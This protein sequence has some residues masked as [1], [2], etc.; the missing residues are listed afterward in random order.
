MEA[1]RNNKAE[2]TRRP[3][4]LHHPHPPKAPTLSV[5]S[6]ARTGQQAWAGPESGAGG[7]S[8]AREL[9]RRQRLSLP[10]ALEDQ[11]RSK[12]PPTLRPSSSLRLPQPRKCQ[13]PT[14]TLPL[15]V[16][17]GK[18]ASAPPT[19][20]APGQRPFPEQRS[21]GRWQAIAPPGRG[22]R[23]LAHSLE[24]FLLALVRGQENAVFEIKRRVCLPAS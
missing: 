4:Q 11:S 5:F 9:S 21:A 8:A 1:V 18:W 23:W 3:R 16:R 22:V 10:L 15:S 12:P 20:C 7:G 13:R 14:F 24:L 17:G 19:P 2:C 6:D